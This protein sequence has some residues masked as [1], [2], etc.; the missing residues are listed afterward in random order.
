MKKII[1]LLLAVSMIA[2]FFAGCGNKKGNSGKTQLVWAMP[3][4][5][6]TDDAKVL[7]E[8][9]KELENVMPGTELSFIYDM[10]MSKKWSLYMAGKQQID[11]AHA[12][13][14]NDLA[15]EINKKSYRPLDEL[16]DKYAPTIKKDWEAY[17]DEFLTGT[18][19]GKLYAIP[20]VQNQVLDTVYLRI[21]VKVYNLFD[22]D[23]FKKLVNSS[24]ILTE[25]ICV[26]LDKYMDA[27]TAYIKANPNSGM[28]NPYIDVEYFYKYFV[29]RG[30]EF[31]STDSN[32]CYQIFPEKD[33]VEIVPF[34]ETSAF[35]TYAKWAST[36][37]KKGYIPQDVLTGMSTSGRTCMLFA[38]I[39]DFNLHDSNSDGIIGPDESPII[40]DPDYYIVGAT[41]NSQKYRGC[42]VIGS[43]L[44]YNTIPT[45]A[46]YPE[47]AMQLLELLRTEKGKR[48]LNLIIYGIEGKHYS[49]T[50]DDTIK[51][52]GYEGTQGTSSSPYGKAGWM[53]SNMMSNQYIIEPFTAD[54]RDIA[55]KY[56]TETAKSFYKTPICGMQVDNANITN[57]LSQISAVLKEYELQITG[58]VSE[59]YE[60]IMSDMKNKMASAGLDTVKKD[61]QKQVKDYI[62]SKK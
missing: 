16:I 25:E 21:P 24:S 56:L 12:G 19:G 53:V 6:Q 41:P 29:K 1:S 62:K 27:A 54:S 17:S 58:G 9:N 43:Q 39:A 18:S 40:S 3:F 52:I 28:T 32:L 8:I 57:E 30:Y 35:K 5:P 2:V 46:K 48:L 4:Y 10:S 44:T 15:T 14:A 55:N 37:Y 26:M 11:I 59:N 7:E 51:A 36:W 22:V 31:F 49:K 33:N 13:F 38:S 60:S 61:Y 34:N 50:G 47:K 23:E 45:T 42:S 20:N